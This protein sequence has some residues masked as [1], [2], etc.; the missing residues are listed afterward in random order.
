MDAKHDEIISM[1]KSNGNIDVI[2]AVVGHTRL[3]SL[4]LNSCLQRI[5]AIYTENFSSRKK[6]ISYLI[7]G[8]ILATTVRNLAKI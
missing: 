7:G 6:Y 8:V 5:Y 3:E 1:K 4:T 2:Q